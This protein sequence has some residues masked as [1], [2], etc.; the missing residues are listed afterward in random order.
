M[1]DTN[2]KPTRGA[3]LDRLVIVGVLCL[4]LAGVA[5]PV[6]V[7]RL[8]LPTATA[9]SAE[10]TSYS[11][12]DIRAIALALDSDDPDEPYE[13]RLRDI[14]AAG[15]RAVCFV[16]PIWQGDAKAS[17]VFI[18]QRR[19]PTE[20]RIEELI[21]L[22]D[23]LGLTTIVMPTLRLDDGGAGEEASP[24]QFL[25]WWEDYE[26]IT[27]F[28]TYLV[29]RAEADAL[30]IGHK[31]PNHHDRELRWRGL[32]GKVRRAYRGKLG[33]VAHPSVRGKIGWWDHLD[34][35]GA[36]VA[37]DIGPMGPRS[38]RRRLREPAPA[39]E[40]IRALEHEFRRPVLY[41]LTGPPRAV[42]EAAAA[43][44]EDSGER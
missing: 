23:G 11:Y 3:P 42:S 35:L 27:M 43:A 9:P 33:Y 38:L 30:V 13:Q 8:S 4:L 36:S 44:T 15:A 5:A 25:R 10:T 37:F 7:D 14:A 21:H 22:A 17:S 18:E 28:F 32:I 2:N 19:M 29:G 31:L 39:G 40:D 6:V 16:I 26:N 34:W 41:I 12:G 20:S 1:D 24:A